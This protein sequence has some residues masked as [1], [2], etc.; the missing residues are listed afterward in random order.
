MA[1]KIRSI[2]SDPR[3]PAFV[4]KYR[5]DWARFAVERIGKEPT[6]QQA[7][8]IESVEQEGSRTTVSSGHGTGKS[9]MTAIMIICFLICFPGA[10]IVIVANNARQVRIGIWKYLKTGLNELYKTTPWLQQY[11]VLTDTQFYE[12]TGKGE[13]E[14]IAKSC[15][16]GNEEALAG[17]HAKHMLV[18]VDE[19]SGV[20][21]AA[22]GVLGGALTQ[23]DNRMLLLSQPTRPAGFFYDTHHKLA[24]PNPNGV[25][26]AIRLN[27]EE[28]PLVTTKFLLEKLQ[29]YGGR[30]SL[31]YLIKV[32]GEFPKTVSGFLL[33]RD[34][35]DKA[36]KA[37]PKLDD[38]WGW[39]ATCDVGNGRDKSVINIS[40]VSGKR[41]KRK[42]VN[43]KRVET[44]N[45]NPVRFADLIYQTCP[46]S[47]YPNITIAID[48]DGVGHDTA[49]L[50]IDKGMRVQRIRWGKKLHSKEDKQRFV[51]QRAQANIFA[52]DAVQ[53]GRMKVDASQT[54]AEQAARIPY[55]LNEAGQLQM[56]PKKQMKEKLNINSPD[57]WDTYCFQ[58]IA[59]Y[60]PASLVLDAS[61][62][63]EVEV[64]DQWMDDDDYDYE[65]I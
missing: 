31:E 61:T 14:V 55:A 7:E 62:Q 3:Y 60:V 38:D 59:N 58:M 48:S 50:C 52:R 63:E 36:V 6:W 49:T 34:E 4:E 53:Q 51:N 43:V 22:L 26:T 28:S 35:I 41:E 8:I 33:G 54:T 20:S 12:K 23:D 29:Q 24:K 1:R 16:L 32:R 30:E 10:R 37:K 40:K 21:D 13:W 19:A 57:T 18:I 39:V 45:H 44:G 64:I 5:Y 65:D 25:W 9:D 11:L 56:M 17:E 2:T 15:R 42:V 46:T 47:L 27:S